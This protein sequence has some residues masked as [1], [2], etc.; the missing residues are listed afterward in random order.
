MLTIHPCP[1]CKAHVPFRSAVA[2]KHWTEQYTC[3]AC[4]LRLRRKS[5][6]RFFTGQLI[7]IALG[8]VVT[9]LPWWAFV[10]ISGAFFY[11]F[12]RWTFELE[13]GNA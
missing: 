1:R 4:N 5:P 3:P 13:P 7:L 8:A 12:F 11:W 9:A 6:Y 10:P 2:T